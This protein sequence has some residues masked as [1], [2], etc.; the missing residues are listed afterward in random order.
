MSLLDDA[1]VGKSQNL[2][3]V[4]WENLE[5]LQTSEKTPPAVCWFGW[6]TWMKHFLI[7]F[8][9]AWL[10]EAAQRFFQSHTSAQQEGNQNSLDL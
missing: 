6:K 3:F 4:F 5:F 8:F 1:D 9:V 7:D 10:P 2:G